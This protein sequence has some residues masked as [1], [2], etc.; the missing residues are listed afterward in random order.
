MIRL[1]IESS[2]NENKVVTFNG[3]TFPKYGWA[4]VLAG[5]PGSGKGFSKEAICIDAKSFDVDELKKRYI[6]ATQRD[7]SIA[8][9][10]PKSDWNLKNSDGV[11]TLHGLVF[12]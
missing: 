11:S 4:V 6:K 2:L 7:T 9:N 8:K 12:A 5:G 3:E 10:S 1:K